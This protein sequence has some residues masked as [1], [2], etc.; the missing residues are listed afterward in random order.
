MVDI[1]NTLCEGPGC[2][3]RPTFAEKG[4]KKPKF[5]VQHAEDGMVSTQTTNNCRHEDCLKQRSFGV[6]GKRAEFCAAHAKHGMVDVASK[7]KRCRDVGCGKR[8]S[9][10]TRGSYKG[11]FCAQHSLAGMV[12]VVSSRKM[13]QHP[14]CSTRSSKG[15][16]G[17]SKAV[18]C[19]KHSLAGMVDVTSF[20]K[21][22]HH[23]GC[24]KRA[25]Y[26]A[27]GAT[28][29]AFCRTHALT[30]MVGLGR[31]RPEHLGRTNLKSVARKRCRH[32]GCNRIS[33]FAPVGA[34]TAKFCAEH[35]LDG[36]VSVSNKERTKDAAAAA[37]A[38][39]QESTPSS[40][41]TGDAEG[42][43]GGERRPLP[44]GAKAFMGLRKLT[45]ADGSGSALLP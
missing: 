28:K 29:P 5:C 26:G 12:D 8:A 13:C 32:S 14:G 27:A 34:E 38:V 33:S 20:S 45:R 2:P 30:G 6:E 25:S 11:V 44:A 18:F 22:C 24:M 41:P 7:N 17:T 9:F 21:M 43:D 39:K 35:A 31:A 42:G 36:M 23:L 10:A 16:V 4:S 19:S 37:V 3:K 40:T 1:Y 15:V